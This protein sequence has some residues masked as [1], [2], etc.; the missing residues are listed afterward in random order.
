LLINAKI[1]KAGKI[2]SNK[3][4]KIES[5][6]YLLKINKKQTKQINKEQLTANKTNFNLLSEMLLASVLMPDFKSPSL[7]SL[8][9]AISRKSVVKKAKIA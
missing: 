8:S 3:Y 9:F 7:S 5:I 1:I 6:V 4:T 2:I